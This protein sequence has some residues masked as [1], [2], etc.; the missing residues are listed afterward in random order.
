[1]GSIYLI[2][3]GQAS[4]G[5]DDYDVLSPIGIRQAEV[6]GAHLAQLGL[7]LDHCY[8]GDLRRQQHTAQA[9]LAQFDAAGLGAPAIQIDPAFNEFDAD[10]VIRALLPDLLTE[11]PEA[12]HVLRNG[13]QNR[14]EFQRLFSKLV[15]RW[16]SGEHDKPD[17]QSWKDFVEQVRGGL[18]RILAEADSKQNIAVFTSGGTITA[19]LHLVTGIPAE[20]AF[21]LNWQIVNTSLNRL[22]FRGSEVTLASF[23]SHVHLELLKAPEL[24]T[25]R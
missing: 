25:Y 12:L 23:N 5:A 17:L 22:K 10:A 13:A 9:A 19:L 14:A 18:E 8:S 24:I 11:E 20:S 7:R 3:H 6:L 15:L 2:R 4:F 21:G 16:V 1:M